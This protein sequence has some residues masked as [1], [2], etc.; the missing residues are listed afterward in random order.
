ME[1]GEHEGSMAI[2]PTPSSGHRRR[3]P[4]TTLQR[5]DAHGAAGGWWMNCRHLSPSSVD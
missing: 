1:N 2:A 3:H 5:D 4:S